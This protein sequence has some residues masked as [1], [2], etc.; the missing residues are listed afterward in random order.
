MESAMHHTQRLAVFTAAIGLLTAPAVAAP[1]LAAR[2]KPQFLLLVQGHNGFAPGVPNIGFGLRNIGPGLSGPG[3]FWGGGPGFGGGR[4]NS[5]PSSPPPP[6]PAPAQSYQPPPS[7]QQPSYQ[8][9]YNNY[10]APQQRPDVPVASAAPRAGRPPSRK[11]TFTRPIPNAQPNYLAT[12]SGV[13]G[14]DVS[15]RPAGGKFANVTSGSQLKAADEISSG[16]ETEV[17][18]TLRDGGTVRLSPATKVDLAALDGDTKSGKPMI[19]LEIGE[20][21]SKVTLGASTGYNLAVRTDRAAVMVREAAFTV[22]HDKRTGATTVSVE[23]GIVRITPANGSLEAVSLLAGQ[24]AEIG[25]DRIETTAV[26]AADPAPA[27]LPAADSAAPK[28]AVPAATPAA[29]SAVRPVSASALAAAEPAAE[30]EL[31]GNWLAQDGTTVQLT[32]DGN[33]VSWSYRGTAGHEARAGT[34]SGRFDGKFLVGTFHEREGDIVGDGTMTLTMD[35]SNRLV[36][37]WVS[38]SQPG[39]TGETVLTR[40]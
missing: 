12:L 11:P 8:P 40:Q 35:G 37:G 4:Y 10:P 22:R 18:L 3:G 26:A 14:D 33:Q 17:T 39:R 32:Q 13:R 23:D 38:T 24:Q 1:P 9:A 25:A 21:S 34:V 19:D 31:T 2:A 28:D 29:A 7:Y 27:T 16:P 20:V 36:G 15:V 6:P 30:R 5:W